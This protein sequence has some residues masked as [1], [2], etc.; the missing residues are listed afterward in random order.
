LLCWISAG[1]HRL[2]QSAHRLDAD[3]AKDVRVEILGERILLSG[4]R[5]CLYFQFA[6]QEAS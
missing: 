2:P 3:T 4:E 5:L 1:C 6:R